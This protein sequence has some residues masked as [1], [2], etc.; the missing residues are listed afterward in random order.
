[1]R[2]TEFLLFLV[3]W[4]P[5]TSYNSQRYKAQIIATCNFL[6]KLA[7]SYSNALHKQIPKNE[8]YTMP[9]LRYQFILPIILLLQLCP[10]LT[11]TWWSHTEPKVTVQPGYYQPGYYV[12]PK[13]V[14][15]P[16]R[17]VW[18]EPAPVIIARSLRRSMPIIY[19]PLSTAEAMVFA[20]ILVVS[21][22]AAAIGEVSIYNKQRN[23]YIH[24]FM[25]AGFTRQQA[26]AL[27]DYALICIH[28]PIYAELA[29]ND[30]RE[31]EVY[32]IRGTGFDMYL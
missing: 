10:S 32:V 30:P 11:H 24:R 18:H 6:L 8:R 20:A 21:G 13:I 4:T 25:A 3:S 7:H 9:S 15:E 22:V 16:A 1:M 29:L 31:F 19:H 26:I 2:I 23:S 28:D 12:E 14:V 27:A 17:R 5:T